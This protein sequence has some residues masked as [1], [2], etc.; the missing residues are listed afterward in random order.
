[1]VL[2]ADGTFIYTPNLDFNGTDTFVYNAVDQRL[3]SDN[4]TTVTITVNRINDA[5]LAGNDTIGQA[6]G[7]F[8][9]RTI[10][11]PGSFFTANDLAHF[12][13]GTSPNA[14]NEAGQALTLVDGGA[15]IVSETTTNFGG[16]GA[17]LRVA[18]KTGQGA[19]GIRL[20]MNS[21][22]LGNG[23]QPTVTVVQKHNL[24]DTQQQRDH[25]NNRGRS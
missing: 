25:S 21:S 11:L 4:P 10:V 1:M 9:D 13:I 18:A 6:N 20:Y 23:T 17:N 14:S 15:T 7:M 2:N 22:D 16:L 12:A 3:K 5:P 19:Y 8:E 24:R